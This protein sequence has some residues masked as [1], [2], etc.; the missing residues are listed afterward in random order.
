MPQCRD[1]I[2]SFT[3]LLLIVFP[4]DGISLWDTFLYMLPKVETGAICPVCISHLL[5]YDISLS[6]P[7]FLVKVQ[8]SF[9]HATMYHAD[10]YTAVGPK[11]IAWGI[12]MTLPQHHKL[13]DGLTILNDFNCATF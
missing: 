2:S 6:V 7:I 4:T 13:D 8:H 5:L 12:P 10:S 3:H 1:S 9:T 11:Q